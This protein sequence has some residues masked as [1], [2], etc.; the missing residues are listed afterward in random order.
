M[1]LDPKKDEHPRKKRL[2]SAPTGVR[3]QD[4]SAEPPRFPPVEEEAEAMQ[5]QRAEELQGYRVVLCCR[6]KPA[7]D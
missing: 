2:V 4:G 5:M 1:M 7:E 3:P 6:T